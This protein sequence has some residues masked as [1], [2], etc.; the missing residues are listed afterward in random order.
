MEIL[1]MPGAA[2][3]IMEGFDELSGLYFTGP[4]QKARAMR[5]KG[6]VEY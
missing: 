1:L 2:P 5:E 4:K 3:V 6:L